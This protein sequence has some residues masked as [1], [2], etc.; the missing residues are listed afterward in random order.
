MSIEARKIAVDAGNIGLVER[1]DA[2]LFIAST[3]LS[4]SLSLSPSLSYFMKI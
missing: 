3:M 1:V 4:L 2:L